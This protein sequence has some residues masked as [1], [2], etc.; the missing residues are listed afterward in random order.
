MTTIIN[1]W[2]ME[3]VKHDNLIKKNGPVFTGPLS[4]F[5]VNL[6]LR[7]QDHLA[8]GLR[9]AHRQVRQ[10]FAVEHDLANPQA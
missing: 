7:R 3:T 9:I 6:F 10:H 4:F 2:S 5:K 1:G 8:E